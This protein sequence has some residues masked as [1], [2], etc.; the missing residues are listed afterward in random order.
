[1]EKDEETDTWSGRTAARVFGANH[2][3]TEIVNYLNCGAK[4]LHYS[5]FDVG[6][7]MFDVQSVLCSMFIFKTNPLYK[8][9]MWMF[10]K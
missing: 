2:K 5:M 6:R 7:S 9:K 10:T 3:E 1:M 8:S 4:R